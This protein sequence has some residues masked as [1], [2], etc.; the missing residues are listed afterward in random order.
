M[1]AADP[2]WELYRSFLAVA[3]GGSLSAAARR[4]RLTQPTLGRHIQALE[5]ALGVA[6]FTRSPGGLAPTAA[7]LDLVPP[8]EAMEA[9]AAALIRAASGAAD[10]THGVVRLTASEMMGGEVLP[11]MLARF[12]AAHPGI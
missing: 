1:A 6:L 2:G 4:L 3:R 11:A 7:A 5:A 10:E 9:A 8:A 12:R